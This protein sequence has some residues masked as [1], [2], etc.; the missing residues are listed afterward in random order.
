MG[1]H[2]AIDPALMPPVGATPSTAVYG[3][4]RYGESSQSFRSLRKAGSF[5]RVYRLDRQRPAQ[6]ADIDHDL[7]SILQA[8]DDAR[9]LQL[10]AG[11]VDRMR[12]Q[13][14]Q[15]LDLSLA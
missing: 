10:A 11:D 4:L 12:A 1:G 13:A 6:V 9:A 2:G 5:R 7:G 15:F 8:G 14:L 3:P